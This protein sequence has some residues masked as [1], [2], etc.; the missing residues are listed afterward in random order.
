MGRLYKLA[1]CAFS[2]LVLTAESVPAKFFHP[3]AHNSPDAE[4]SVDPEYRVMDGG[5]DM[6]SILL[7]EAAKGNE[8]L[9]YSSWN[10]PQLSKGSILRYGRKIGSSLVLYSSKYTGTVNAGTVGSASFIGNSLFSM[11]IP[12]NV[13]RQEQIAVYFRH[14]P[15][16]GLGVRVDATNQ[17]DR[18]RLG[19]NMGVKVV[20]VLSGSP[21]FLSDILPGDIIM[22][23]DGQSVYEGPSLKA[24]VAG[25]Y[26]KKSK[27]MLNRNGVEVAKTIQ[28][29]GDGIW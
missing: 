3:S 28:L 18:Q 7:S 27:I 9:G 8:L 15:R 19:T 17:E 6:P 13:N 25:S 26:G 4:V 12:I 23:I 29:A 22:S 21:A 5:A 11:A 14:A 16:T 24:A 20:G 2:I 1:F 10:G